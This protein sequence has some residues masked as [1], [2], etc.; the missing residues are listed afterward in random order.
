MSLPTDRPERR[1]DIVLPT[2]GWPEVRVSAWFARPG[3]HV[4]SGDRLVEVIG[5]GATFDVAAPATGRLASQS[6][7]PRD[8]V[9]PGAILGTL[10][11]DP[12]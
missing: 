8:I 3:D 11:A 10:D 4:Y 7:F 5:A 1:I 6:A 12:E 2:L 9:G